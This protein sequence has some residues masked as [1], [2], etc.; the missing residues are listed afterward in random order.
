MINLLPWSDSDFWILEKANTKEMTT[1]I[2][3]PESKEEITKRHNKY[4]DSN[5]PGKVRM[6]KI[7]VDDIDIGSIGYW[8]IT[9]LDQ[10]VYETG[11]SVLPPYQKRG[12]ATLATI[13]LIK[14]LFSEAKHRYL[15]AFPSVL[16]EP[17]NRICSKIGFEFQGECD[18][19]CSPQKIMRSNNW[20]FDLK[21]E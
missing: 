11:W 10:L 1:F 15:H 13:A 20:R 3:G 21:P 2:G 17:S 9:L 18:F 6:F 12:H 4:L 14:I 19:E 5:N 7:S 16:N 8:E